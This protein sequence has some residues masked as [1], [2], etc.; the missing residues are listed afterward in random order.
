[1]ALL[2]ISIR[3]L[4]GLGLMVL[5]FTLMYL[6]IPERKS[7]F[8]AELPGAILT[9]AGWLGFSYLYSYYIDHIA[10]YN[11]TYGSLTAIVLCMIWVYACMYIM[12]IGAEVN[13]VFANPTRHQAARSLLQTLKK[14]RS[15]A[16]NTPD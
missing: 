16:E 3:T 1:M 11:A 10:N 7:S 9:S 4:V 14:R 2:I 6:L 8:F 12:F 5:F 15:K 13:Q